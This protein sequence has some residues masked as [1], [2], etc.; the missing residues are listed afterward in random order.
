MRKAMCS[1]LQKSWSVFR[2]SSSSVYI[3]DLSDPQP[4]KILSWLIE[5]RGSAGEPDAASGPSSPETADTE[6]I[7]AS[8]PLAAY[9]QVTDLTKPVNG[10]Y[11]FMIS[12][13]VV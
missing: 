10:E 12:F 6:A 8:E 7:Q 13:S 3:A 5:G 1:F 4:G 9:T 2:H 11:A